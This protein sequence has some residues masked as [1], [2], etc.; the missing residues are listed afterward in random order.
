VGAVSSIIDDIFAGFEDFGEQVLTESDF[1]VFLSFLF[2]VSHS[3]SEYH[4]PLECRG[5]PIVESV[6]PRSKE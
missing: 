2:N 1:A 3:S 5:S 6:T 4:R